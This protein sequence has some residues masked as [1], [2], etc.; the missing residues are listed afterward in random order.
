V[1]GDLIRE[2]GFDGRGGGVYGEF[3]EVVD[4]ETGGSNFPESVCVL[5]GVLVCMLLGVCVCVVRACIYI[6]QSA[7]LFVHACM[8]VYMR[9]YKP[10]HSHIRMYREARCR[11]EYG[12]D[13]RGG[14]CACED[15]VCVTVLQRRNAAD[16]YNLAAHHA[17]NRHS[18]PHPHRIIVY[19]IHSPVRWR[20]TSIA[21][22]LCEKN[23][24]G[25]A[26]CSTAIIS[27]NWDRSESRVEK[28][29]M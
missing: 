28:S 14:S 29:W 5:V 18:S 17:A 4:E 7:V 23:M 13:A 3:G 8:R 11:H 21:P 27:T 20:T 25:T 26:S 16:C 9:V 15:K 24:R 19:K 12:L 10:R 6:C 2:M 22:M 1:V